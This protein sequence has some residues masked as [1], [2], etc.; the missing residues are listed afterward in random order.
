[1]T[2]ASIDAS[3]SQTRAVIADDGRSILLTVYVAAETVAIVDLDPLWALGLGTQLIEAGR[4]HLSRRRQAPARRR[5]GGDPK[6][7]L[8]RERDAAFCALARL[9]APGQP[10]EEQ[11][12]LVINRQRRYQPV[13][14]ET[15]ED[16]QLMAQIKASGL[17]V[18]SLNRM[19]RIL[20]VGPATNRM[21]G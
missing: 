10:F 17:A 18:P 9:L 7:A 13:A 5:R 19:A 4:Q 2:I 12:R 16:R 6:A 20:S 21:P 11:A 14:G 3:G 8:R 15:G 1:M